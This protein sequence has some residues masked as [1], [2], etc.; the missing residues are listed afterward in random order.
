M[1][2]T[3]IN[4]TEPLVSVKKPVNPKIQY[5]DKYAHRASESETMRKAFRSAALKLF[6]R[7]KPKK[8]MEI[9]SNDGALI[10]NF[11][12]ENVIGIEP[13]SNLAKITE[14]KGYLTYRKYWN[15]RLA[16]ELKNKHGE[17]DL[18]YSANTLTH[19]SNLNDVF[20]AISL[21]LSRDGILIIED[22]SLLE[23]IKKISYDQFYNEHIYVFSLMA[24]SK[25]S[26]LEGIRI[27]CRGCLT[28]IFS[29]FLIFHILLKSLSVYQ[30]HLF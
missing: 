20:K 1:L 5:T 27:F 3:H 17:I 28:L 9:G 18:I 15:Y 21:L 12:K 22:P 25:D 10:A 26:P 19:I 29:F 16:N 8:I 6:K 30:I 23:C 14:K 24:I 4:H 13:C 2:E 7:F 11:N